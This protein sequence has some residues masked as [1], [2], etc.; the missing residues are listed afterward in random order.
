MQKSIKV[1]VTLN[2]TVCALL[3]VQGCVNDPTLW[4]TKKNRTPPAGTQ[5]GT[6]WVGGGD[7]QEAWVG[8]GNQ[9]PL[10][11][12]GHP[13]NPRADTVGTYTVV[14]GDTLSEIALRHGVTVRDLANHNGIADPNRIRVGQV[15]EIPAA[16]RTPRGGSSSSGGSTSVDRQSIPSDGKYTVQEGDFPGKIAQKFGIKTADLMA[17]NPQITDPTRLRVGQVLT[18]PGGTTSTAATRPTNN[19]TR[20]TTSASTLP[21]SLDQADT[22]GIIVI[23]E[24]VTPKTQPTNTNGGVRTY[25][26]RD[27][28]D[29][30][31]VAVRLGVSPTELRQLNGLTTSEL[32]PGTV[33][34]VP[35]A[36]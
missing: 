31:S 23:E 30:Y 29:V 1:M 11:P 9:Q 2:A 12:A 20:T 14:K 22:V 33:I 34:K 26:V 10:G 8:G 3:L 5:E 36:R 17:A 16:T 4:R 32:T 25:T 28:D 35:A 6:G 19:N 21:P 15:L 18:I 13:N 24:E 7:Q 27:G